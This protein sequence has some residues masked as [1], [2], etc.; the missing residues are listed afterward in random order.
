[1]TP[2]Q[3]KK[4]SQK[5]VDVLNLKKGIM[6]TV[7][8]RTLSGA[9]QHPDLFYAVS[10][11]SNGHLAPPMF[12]TQDLR[13]GELCLTFD[14]LLTKTDFVPLARKVLSKIESEYGRPVDVEFAWDENRLYILQCRSLST[15]KELER[16]GHP[17][18]PS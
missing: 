13:S 14:N 2:E 7:D 17:L 16:G 18:K 1:V 9:I 6:E 12:R 11:Q 10:L 8:F 3:I 4:Y 5:Q 15:R